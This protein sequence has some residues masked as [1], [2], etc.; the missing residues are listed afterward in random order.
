MGGMLKHAAYLLEG[1]MLPKT[2]QFY[3]ENLKSK[4]GYAKGATVNDLAEIKYSLSCLLR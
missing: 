4:Y 3:N 1:K 2:Q